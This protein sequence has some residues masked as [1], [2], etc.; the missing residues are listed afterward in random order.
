MILKNKRGDIAITILVI[1]VIVLCTAALI[2]FASFDSLDLGGGIYS[3]SYLQR[4][5]NTADSID[6]A[7]NGDE[8][9]GYVVDNGEIEK[10]FFNGDLKIEYKI[11]S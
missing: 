2:A 3:F 5:Y 8:Y 7:G 11:G 6:Y 1:A 9:K 10:S 4:V